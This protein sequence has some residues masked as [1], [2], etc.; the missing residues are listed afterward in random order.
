[1]AWK[2]VMLIVSAVCGPLLTGCAQP[3]I[4]SSPA[5]PQDQK[6]YGGVLQAASNPE[7][8]GLY[9][10]DSVAAAAGGH[11]TSLTPAFDTLMSYRFTQQGEDFQARG[12]GGDLAPSL[13]ES[14]AQ[15][16][17]KTYVFN[18]RKGVK[19]H[20]GEPFTAKDVR[21]SI[22]RWG[23]P[24]AAR[25][26]KSLNGNM[27]AIDVLDSHTIRLRLKEA[28][29]GFLERLADFGP[30]ILPSHPAEKA[31]VTGEALKELYNKNA[32]GTGPFKVR[33][34]TRNKSMELER[35]DD[36]WA[37]RPYMDGIRV[38]YGLDRSTQQAA[39]VTGEIDFMS[40]NDKVQYEVLE[41]AVPGTQKISYVAYNTTGAFVNMRR[42]PLN[43][44]RVRK[45]I[46]L[47]IDRQDMLNVVTFGEG[48]IVPPPPVIAVMARVGWGMKAEEFLALPGFRQ[49]K[50]QDRAEARQ[51]LAQ[52]G[53]PSGLRLTLKYRRGAGAPPLIAEPFAAQLRTVGI[54]AIVQPMED[55]AYVAG[56][57]RDKDFELALNTGGGDLEASEAG[58]STFHSTS[59]GNLSGVNDPDLDALLIQAKGELDSKKRN[60]LLIRVQRIMTD[61]VYHVPLVNV[62]TFQALQPWLHGF[63]GSFSSSISILNS[64]ATWMEVNKMPSGRRGF[65]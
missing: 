13:A 38:L 50:E 29:I 31:G 54:Q 19:W 41:K 12:A 4:D 62:A 47:A 16:D 42:E 32:I 51:L 11:R 43:D 63:H 14:W 36:H 52:A 30:K 8:T 40:L 22:E 24:P 58:A 3:S 9:W 39:F 15:P 49:P 33:A 48:A 7:P 1:M 57:E 20:D 23:D 21:W 28:A 35:F 2:R 34:F 6:Q 26:L 56:V 46:H 65:Q 18:L 55:G 61:K 10:Y 60:E 27:A 45:A 64:H 37:G 25:D 53:H 5:Q 59:L 17:P 44:V